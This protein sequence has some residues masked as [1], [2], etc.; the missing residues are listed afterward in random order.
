[1]PPSQL[2]RLKSSLRQQGITG[3]QKSKKQKKSAKSSS[4]PHPSLDRSKKQAALQQIRDSFNPFEVQAP[5]RPTKFPHASISNGAGKNG[6]RYKDVLHRPGVT[7]SA[8][9]ELR[10]ATLLPEVRRR[11]KVGGL[12]DRRIGEGESGMTAEERAARR[13]AEVKG[14]K[15]V[16]DLEGSDD[17]DVGMGLT[18]GGRKLDDLEE[19]DFGGSPAASDGE[20]SDGFLRKKRPR[21]ERNIEDDG[22]ALSDFGDQDASDEEP[23]RKKSKREVMEEVVAKSKFHKY[24][25]Q[26]AKED[27]DDLREELDKGMD[28]LLSLLRG[29]KKP[30]PPV[31]ATDVAP[32]L[33]NGNGPVM[34]AERAKLLS[35]ADPETVAKEYDARV[36]QLAREQ[37]AKPADRTKTEEERIKEEAE[38]LKALEDR[39]AKRMRGETVS[40]DDIDTPQ[41]PD[42]QDEEPVRDDAAEFGFASSNAPESN[43]KEKIV[44]EEE[45]DFALDENLIASGSDIDFSDASDSEGDSSNEGDGVRGHEEDEEDEFVK[46]I[47]GG[48]GEAQRVVNGESTKSTERTGLAFTYPCPRSHSELLEILKGTA[49]E[50]LPT[51][52]QRIRALYHPSLNADNKEAVAD[53]STV[54][55][56]HLSHMGIS[57]Q[58]LA[59]TEQVIRHLHSLSRTYPESIATA[60]RTQLQATNDRKDLHAGDLVVFTAIGSIYPTSDHFH[61]VVTP[62]ITIMAKWLAMNAPESDQK[63]SLG[64]ALITLS[65][66]YQRLSKRYCPEAVRFILRA[67]KSKATPAGNL[68]SAYCSSLSTMAN[69]WRSKPA[70]IEIFEPFVEP[71]ERISKTQRAAHSKP[72]NRALQSLNIMLSQTRSER[73]PLELHH[74]RPL[75][76]RTQIPRFEETFDPDKHYDP[77]KDRSDA[78]KLQREYKRERKGAIR[79]LRKDSQF[80]AREGLREKRERDAEYEKKQRRLIAEIQGEEGKEA[81]EYEREKGRRK[82]RVGK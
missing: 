82:K 54:L 46:G 58:P 43:G 38:R 37:K 72:A 42:E 6:G 65:L 28:D 63:H 60:F 56:E 48:P 50:Q 80:L 5:S 18:H 55:V 49:V 47:L 20:E 39:R 4:A 75:A 23:E 66:H 51:I 76:I 61:Q 69:L 45:D 24:E 33:A 57:R 74:H 41:Q 36:K 11:N 52:I 64:L 2:K 53:F 35:G 22:G 10:R 62:A 78:K 7:R 67:L 26:K 9:E 79:E 16:F 32:V 81:K 13:F 3:P 17:E 73:K 44:L 77:D 70:F 59:V 71:L 40:D 29:Y 30:A 8:G 19:D 27:D 12:V 25:R 1:M 21:A 31:P 14:R 68:L 15:S 34:N